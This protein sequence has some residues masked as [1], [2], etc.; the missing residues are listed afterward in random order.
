MRGRKRPAAQS[1]REVYSPAKDRSLERRRHEAK[2]VP[3]RR[4]PVVP[5]GGR[6]FEVT[7]LGEVVWE[8]TNPYFF[9]ARVFG[10]TNAVFRARR[11]PAELFPR[12]SS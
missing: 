6:M 1:L 7:P 12:L 4:R 10:N 5:G 3:G 8:Y 11:Y 2:P 9:Q